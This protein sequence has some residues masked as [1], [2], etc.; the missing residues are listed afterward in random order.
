MQAEKVLVWFK[1]ITKDVVSKNLILICW[2]L[3]SQE[4]KRITVCILN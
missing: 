2:D 1:T 3:A 4:A